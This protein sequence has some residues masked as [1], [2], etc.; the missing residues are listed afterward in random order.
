[1]NNK[2]PSICYKMP[3]IKTK[4][5]EKCPLVSGNIPTVRV[6]RV[7]RGVTLIEL[8]IA[9][10][11]LAVMLGYGVPG[12]RNFILNGRITTYSNDLL[13]ELATARSEAIKRNN[14]VVICRSNNPTATPPSCASDASGTWESGWIIFEDGIT[15]KN[16]KFS[17][18]DAGDVLIRVHEPVTGSLTLRNSDSNLVG[19]V[20]F[21]KDGL[22]T[23]P[24][25]AT[26]DPP[27][28]FKLCDSRGKDY[29]RAIVLE[30]T[31]RARIDR[32]STLSTLTCP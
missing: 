21:T 13:G 4:L 12:F 1:M 7:N 16:N 11:V 19:L 17:T 2:L 10:V 32:L 9:F 24:A 31:G 15:A 26:S 8:M 14:T 25:V 29:A 22:T 20:A 28:H 6:R 3:L 27:H 23:L 18:S 5:D 30:S